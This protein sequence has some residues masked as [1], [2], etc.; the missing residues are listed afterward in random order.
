MLAAGC[1]SAHD[2]GEPGRVTFDGTSAEGLVL[3]GEGPAVQPRGRCAD[4]RDRGDGA[5][6]AA[7]P[8]PAH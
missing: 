2:A 8:D 6:R 3:P 5:V 4:R 7:Q 1:V